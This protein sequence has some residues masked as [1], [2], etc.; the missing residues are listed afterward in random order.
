MIDHPKYNRLVSYLKDLGNVAI[1]FSGGVDST[2]LLAVAAEALNDNVIALTV[3][4][5]YIA[6]W[7]IVEAVEL[8]RALKIRHQIVETDI[9]D[10]IRKNPPDRCYL[11]KR[12][13]FSTLL[14]IARSSGIGNVLD[15]T[16]MDD[17]SDH[18]PGIKALKELGIKSPLQETGINKA[19]VRRFSEMLGLPT[20]DKPSYACLLTRLPHGVEIEPGELKRIELAEKFL[21]DLG[22]KAVRVRSHGT[23]A[24]IEAD[25]DILPELSGK[26]RAGMVVKK[27][28]DL[29]FTFVTLDLE[30][31][32]TGSFNTFKS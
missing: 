26:N 17:P 20:W 31:Y 30:G 6:E 25:P 1:A 14:D 23:I 27:F 32:R 8:C 29:G 2:F 24:R 21:M 16:N 15:G 4:A 28:R 19:E 3:K 5:P 9:P 11:C 7:E 10:N 12:E 22:Y 13:I 18:R